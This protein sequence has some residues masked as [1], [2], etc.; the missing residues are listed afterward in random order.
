M[1]RQLQHTSTH[2]AAKRLRHASQ[3]P[4]STG[5]CIT[6]NCEDTT[7]DIYA[8]TISS[9]VKIQMSPQMLFQ[10]IKLTQAGNSAL[11]DSLLSQYQPLPMWT[12][13]GLGQTEPLLL[14]TQHTN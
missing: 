12:S 13:P 9:N 7:E 6:G 5:H 1:T 3:G 4:T 11:D 2:V 10:N 14:Q 8:R